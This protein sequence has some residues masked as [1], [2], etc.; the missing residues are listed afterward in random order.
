VLIHEKQSPTAVQWEDHPGADQGSLSE[1]AAGSDGDVIHDAAVPGTEQN[2]VS[3][4]F[5]HSLNT[6]LGLFLRLRYP[7]FVQA[8]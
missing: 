8:G 5:N 6:Y 3:M 4:T 1:L 7:A 2:R